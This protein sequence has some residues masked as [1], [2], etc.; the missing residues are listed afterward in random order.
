MMKL[1]ILVAAACFVISG[2]MLASA[3]TL[4]ISKDNRS[5]AITATDSVAAEAEIANV[6]IGFVAYGADKDS[7]YASGSRV[8]NGIAKALADAGLKKETIQSTSQSVAPLNQFEL[9]DAPPGAAFRVMQS[10]SVAT[11]PAD[12]A[13]VL[14]IAVKAGAN[15]SGG[16]YW[17]V[18]D[19]DALQAR[20]SAKA[21]ARARSIAEQMAAGLGI[22]LGALIYA[23]NEAPPAAPRP[24]MMAQSG[25]GP[26]AGGAIG[27][28]VAPLA[29]NAR[30]VERSATVYAVFAID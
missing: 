2:A 4:Q 1:K 22:H 16:I 23:S 26:G 13:R 6:Q 11:D 25:F 5:I 20:A 29:I 28:G 9:K 30:R 15:Q 18:K 14:D 17:E 21:L 3:Q 27:S 12:A 10:W 7:A 8:S 19:S 24:V